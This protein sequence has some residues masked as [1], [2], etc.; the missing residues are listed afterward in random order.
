MKA[1]IVICVLLAQQ[2]LGIIYRLNASEYA[3]LPEL[4]FLD[5]YHKCLLAPGDTYCYVDAR[6]VTNE[7][8]QLF[9]VIQEYSAYRKT[10]FDHTIVHRGVCVTQTCRDYLDNSTGLVPAVEACLNATL[11]KSHGLQTRVLEDFVYCSKYGEPAGYDMVDYAAVLLTMV[12]VLLNVAGSF[13][14]YVGCT[15]NKSI[16]GRLLLCFSFKRNWNRLRTA[17][18][19]GP[20][21]RL[22]R[23]KCFTGLKTITTMLVIMAHSPLNIAISTSNPEFLENLYHNAA[24]TFIFNGTLIVQTF[25]LVSGFLLAYNMLLMEEKRPISWDMLPKGILIRWLRL[26][27]VN[28]VVLAFVATWQRHLGSGPLWK[29]LVHKETTQCRRD[30]FYN[31]LYVNNYVDN[32]DCMPHTWYLG[33]DMQLS[34]LGLVVFCLVTSP[35]FRKMAVAAAFVV[36]V[37]TPAVHVNVQNLSPILLVSPE[38]ARNIFVT[39]PTFNNLYKRGH[40][41]LVNYAVGLASA[42]LVYELQQHKF[43]VTKYKKYT[44]LYYGLLLF[45]LFLISSGSFLYIDGIEVPLAARAVY[46]SAL[47]LLYGLALAAGVSG[48]VFKFENLY[49]GVLEWPVWGP[50]GRLSY[51]AFLVHVSI[52]RTV[53]GA[54]A[55]LAFSSFNKLVMMFLGVLCLSYIIAVP[56]WMLIEVPFYE[57]V[58]VCFYPKKREH[59]PELTIHQCE[60]KKDIIY[61]EYDRLPPLFK[62]EDYY[63]CLRGPGDR[64]CYV[65]AKLVANGSSELLHVIQ[66]YSAAN[67]FT[68]YDHNLIHWGICVTKTCRQYLDNHTVHE[69]LEACLN[70]SLQQTHQLQARLVKE[71]VY[72]TDFEETDNIDTGEIVV[73]VVLI[74]ILTLNILGTLYDVCCVSKSVGKWTYGLLV[75]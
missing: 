52:I 46:A 37:I 7:T 72:C 57:V 30:W 58:K 22:T 16:G 42:M 67:N 74:T 10:H 71:K 40:T 19:V 59:K 66:E 2:A 31:L 63:P 14:D 9:T 28:A 27:P 68:H 73:A 3:R 29:S 51:A 18:G 62:L 33:A 1:F 39:D 60:G 34:V 32:S 6:L 24:A 43:D 61:T 21:P 8:N 20:E 44:P 49:R 15:G 54:Y 41:N 35:K 12:L 53:T 11:Y 26:A 64:Y 55:V 75:P 48:A 17:M 70:S 69:T 38:V 4:F 5:H 65:D 23:L 56:L 25:F 36:G 45:G 50:L 47:R 13:I